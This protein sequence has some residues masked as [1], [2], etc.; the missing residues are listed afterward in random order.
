MELK[1]KILQ[2]LDNYLEN[3]SEED[4][5]ADWEYL[6]QFNEPSEKE[7]LHDNIFTEDKRLMDELS[8]LKAKINKM[9]S[10]WFVKYYTNPDGEYAEYAD[11]WVYN[12]SNPEV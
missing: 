1:H 3:A 8:R 9:C 5:K 10:D 7:L 11:E 12:P 6:R 4:I 2:K